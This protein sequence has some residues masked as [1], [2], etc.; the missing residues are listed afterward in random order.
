VSADGVWNGWSCCDQSAPISLQRLANVGYI[1]EY[2]VLCDLNSI[3]ELSH[4]DEDTQ[5]CVIVLYGLQCWSSRMK[6]V[7]CIPGAAAETERAGTQFIPST[8]HTTH[9]PLLTVQT[10]VSR[11]VDDRNSFHCGFNET[12]LDHR[13]VI[14]QC[15]GG[16]YGL[17]VMFN[18]MF[19]VNY[20]YLKPFK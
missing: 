19:N 2:N 4:S 11:S 18:V 3:G 12:G 13:C 8:A 20:S 7:C 1:T 17:N 15:L 5:V 9:T 16:F 10:C 6:C 14:H